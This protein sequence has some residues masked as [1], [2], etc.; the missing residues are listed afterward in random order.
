MRLPN[1]A[2]W[3]YAASAGSTA[4][5]YGDLDKIV[6]YLD[7]SGGKTHATERLQAVRH[8]GQRL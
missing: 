8:A 7:N 2:E 1:E 3:E 4:A 5:R 6:W